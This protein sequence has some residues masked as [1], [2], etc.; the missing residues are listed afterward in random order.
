MI[1]QAI[2]L[3]YLLVN[4]KKAHHKHCRK[5]LSANVKSYFIENNIYKI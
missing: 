4:N 3:S 5:T 1:I 2:I